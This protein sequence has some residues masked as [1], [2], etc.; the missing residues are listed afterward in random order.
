M[1]NGLVLI[2]TASATASSGPCAIVLWEWKSNEKTS[3]QEAVCEGWTIWEA[4][5]LLFKMAV[6]FGAMA[7]F[8]GLIK[9]TVCCVY[10]PSSSTLISNKAGNHAVAVFEEQVNSQWTL[11]S[12]GEWAKSKNFS[13]LRDNL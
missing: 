4:V 13:R 5:K 6:V 10:P 8:W 3:R 7:Y 1:E 2:A 9:Q 12:F 11:M